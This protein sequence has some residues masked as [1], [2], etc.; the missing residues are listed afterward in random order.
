MNDPDSL[1]E[2]SISIYASEALP[3]LVKA[4]VL[5]FM[6]I[7][8][9]DGYRG[10]QQWRDEVWPE[11][12]AKNTSHVVL[13][14]RGLVMSHA[15]IVW[16]TIHHI[17]EEFS[18]GGMT[19]VFTFPNFKGQGHGIRAVRAASE[20][21]RRSGADLGLTSSS[22]PAFYERAGWQTMPG[23]RV[24]YGNPAHPNPSPNRFSCC[25]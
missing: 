3:P 6:R 2:G 16:K 25:S 22:V 24:M 15:G 21:I 1:G 10:N 4:Q 13:E 8:W 23:T 11:G 17:G 7:E 19:G 12:Q 14:E 18:V 5:S 20:L 9:A